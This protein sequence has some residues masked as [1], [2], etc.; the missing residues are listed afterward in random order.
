MYQ[1]GTEQ[2]WVHRGR[3]LEPTISPLWAVRFNQL[4]NYKPLPY[5]CLVRDEKSNSLAW[6]F[7]VLFRSFPHL[8]QNNEQPRSFVFHWLPRC[9]STLTGTSL[10][11][12]QAPTSSGSR[13]QPIFTKA[14][15]GACM[16][17]LRSNRSCL[18]LFN[19]EA[20]LGLKPGIV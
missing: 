10:W 18:F 7:P 11:L 1:I 12:V 3:G 17:R 16:T 14:A 13:Q 9:S 19:R 2:L 4:I 8:T 20:P 15:W 6:S 5:L